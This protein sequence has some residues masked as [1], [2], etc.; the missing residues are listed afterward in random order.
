[1][2]VSKVAKFEFVMIIEIGPFFFT[3][4]SIPAQLPFLPN[5]TN[6]IK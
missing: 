3:L 5:R 4:N 1:M 2:G 6:S